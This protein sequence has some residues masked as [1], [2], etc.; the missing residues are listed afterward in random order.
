MHNLF[1]QSLNFIKTNI[2]E[3]NENTK[4]FKIR[5]SIKAAFEDFHT[6]HT[7]RSFNNLDLQD[8]INT[9]NRYLCNQI[10]DNESEDYFNKLLTKEINWEYIGLTKF[11]NFDFIAVL[12]ILKNTLL[13]GDSEISN[14]DEYIENIIS[15]IRFEF[16]KIN[17]EYY[18]DRIERSVSFFPKNFPF[19]LI[20][21]D[22]FMSRYFFEIHKKIS[23]RGFKELF[24]KYP[25]L[26]TNSKFLE[27]VLS[28]KGITSNLKSNEMFRSKLYQFFENN[29]TTLIA[30][31]NRN[32]SMLEYIPENLKNNFEIVYAA[33]EN[34]PNAYNFIASSLKNN[35]SIIKL[36]IQ[37]GFLELLPNEVKDDI[38]LVEL[39]VLLHPTTIKHAS[40][41]IKRN[42]NLLLYALKKD[43]SID[44]DEI[45][46]KEFYADEEFMTQ[47]ILLQPRSFEWFYEKKSDLFQN[48]EVCKKVLESTGSALRILSEENKNDLTLVNIAIIDNV[49]NLQYAGNQIRSNKDFMYDLLYK[50]PI[51]Y[52]YFDESLKQDYELT[53][54]I[55]TRSPEAYA[56]L[57][58]NFKN[59]PK[60]MNIILN[61]MFINEGANNAEMW[62]VMGREDDESYQDDQ[63]L[64]DDLPF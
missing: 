5:K 14:L 9:T 10:I 56:Y 31:I 32:G 23:N 19:K 59:D 64:Q 47:A 28:K 48:Q 17:V 34:D 11:S 50:N 4:C 57:P 15:E 18:D 30:V 43:Y 61:N 45:I 35:P 20:D 40:L 63:N 38:E 62:P 41:K 51:A 52:C 13:R 29:R 37:K 60:I 1:P 49:K 33:I 44:L 55:I 21:N 46:P 6:F 39:S 54:N 36:M 25:Y 8:F 16:F 58:I 53:I 22:M 24:E 42:K 26:F 27:L 2:F 12:I 7:G 3:F